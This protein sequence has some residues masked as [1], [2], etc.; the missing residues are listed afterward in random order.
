M[1]NIAHSAAQKFSIYSKLSWFDQWIFRR[2][3]RW[4]SSDSAS[5]NLLL[6]FEQKLEEKSLFS[7]EIFDILIH[8][9]RW[10]N[11][12]DHN[13]QIKNRLLHEKLPEMLEIIPIFLDKNPRLHFKYRDL[14]LNIVNAANE[15]NKSSTIS[16][17]EFRIKTAESISKL[18]SREK[19]NWRY[20]ELY[21]ENGANYL[22]NSYKNIASKINDLQLFA[23]FQSEAEKLY[24]KSIWSS[25]ALRHL[26]S[27]ADKVNDVPS[28]E[29]VFQKIVPVIGMQATAYLLAIPKDFQE[30]ENYYERVATQLA[31]WDIDC[32]S[33]LGHLK[34]VIESRETLIF[35]ETLLTEPQMQKCVQYHQSKNTKYARICL[36]PLK[37]IERFLPG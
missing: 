7:G 17:K 14:I 32:I 37:K 4:V 13:E 5:L 12:E 21:R 16:P 26:E 6:K 3:L 27:I 30:F 31:T 9:L 36:E 11:R 25:D 19:N 1:N 29:V 24:Y 22:L 18:P 35:L 34:N 2:S 10:Y 23:R 28:F 15:I 20:W 8:A 33:L